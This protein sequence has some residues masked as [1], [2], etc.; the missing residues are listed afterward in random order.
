MPSRR[1]KNHFYRFL[2]NLGQSPIAILEGLQFLLILWVLFRALAGFG[3]FLPYGE[4]MVGVSKWLL[5]LAGVHLLVVA[6]RRERKG[7]D[8]E[9]LVPLPIV[10]YAWLHVAFLSPAP[11]DGGLI[12]VMLVQAYVFYYIVYNSIHGSRSGLWILSM[13]QLVVVIALLTAFFQFYQFPEWMV[14]LDRERN[15]AY[16]YGAA[17]LLLDPLNLGS[18]LILAFPASV[19]IVVLRRFSGPVR[20]LNGFYILAMFV[21]LVLS[22]HR[23]GLGI[24]AAV[25]IVLPFF[26]SKPGIIRWKFWRYGFIAIVVA[27]PLFWFATDALRI[28]ILYFL[29]YPRDALADASLAAAWAQFVENP[30]FGKGL[31]SFGL[32][33]EAY[34]PEWAEGTSIYP[35]S[36]YAGILAGLGTIGLICLLGPVLILFIR[37]FRVWLAVPYLT[38]NKDVRERINRF[39]KGH[40]SRAKIER[41]HGRAPSSKIVLGSLLLG[42][43][44]FLVYV[45]WDYSL[46]LPLHVLLFACLLGTLAAFSRRSRRRT[47]SPYLGLA[48]GAIPLLLATW[49]IV[50]G[51]PRL[52]SQYYV[53]T[54]NE[55]LEYLLDDP[56]RIFLD[57]GVVTTVIHGY[58]LAASLNPGHAGAWTGIG[59]GSL[60]RLYADLWN[61][62]ELAESA[63]PALRRALELAPDSWLAHY[64]MARAQAIV[65]APANLVEEH[66]QRSME[67]A[68][69]R[70]EPP[71]FLGSL[72]LLRDPGSAEG[73][74]L[75]DR[76][77]AL[78]ADYEPV[79][80]TLRRLDM[81]REGT[82]VGSVFTDALLAEQFEVIRHPAERILGAGIMPQP[83]EVVPTPDEAG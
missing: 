68:P 59:R 48:T 15:P 23:P 58:Q 81:S 13:C 26:L 6:F 40:P 43:P 25:L 12:L 83:E 41:S 21:G 18:L 77:L 63:E 60:A 44:A 1:H 10:L 8:W 69:Y 78:N 9:L 5:V 45:G 16:L 53:Y 47:V 20:I 72:L 80:N 71:G 55:K 70:P 64:E 46:Q 29:D 24:L 82:A 50:Y 73:R 39:P 33:W 52:Q 74:A 57:P 79:Q 32:L 22:T 28:R 37:G 62:S 30:V 61:P 14:T 56:D 67:L 38:V 35:V 2:H 36:S 49:A 17:G 27:L 34:R 65:G 4:P 66:L 42:I 7:L 75:V 31:G 54:T 19:V 3:G 51:V 11:W 76:A